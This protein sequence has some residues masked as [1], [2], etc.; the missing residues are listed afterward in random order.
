[1]NHHDTAEGI[2]ALGPGEIGLDLGILV[3]LD[4]D[5]LGGKCF[6]HATLLLLAT[7]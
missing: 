3:A 7:I 2:D 6:V 1:M 5:R 4:H